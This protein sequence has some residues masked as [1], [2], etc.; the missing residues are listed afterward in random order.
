MAPA[1]RHRCLLERLVEAILG[2]ELHALAITCQI[3]FRHLFQIAQRLGREREL[4]RALNERVVVAAVGPTCRA[5]LQV[6][7]VEAKVVPEHPKMGPLVMALMRYLDQG[8]PAR[9][10]PGEAA[11]DAEHVARS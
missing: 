5:I 11:T 9:A 4:V 3:Q 8:G 1:G 2:G 7:G 6:H 10:K